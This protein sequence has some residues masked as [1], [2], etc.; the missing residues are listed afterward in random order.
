MCV[1]SSRSLGLRHSR[2][3][4]KC[5]PPL[6]TMLFLHR[7]S[8]TPFEYFALNDTRPPEGQGRG[9]K[10]LQYLLYVFFSIVCVVNLIEEFELGQQSCTIVDPTGQHV[11][12]NRE[13]GLFLCRCWKSKS[14]SFRDRSEIARQIRIR[15]IVPRLPDSIVGASD[16]RFNYSNWVWARPYPRV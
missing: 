15:N 8:P 14:P 7:Q 3:L 4:S 12:I 5:L 13:G 1:R 6:P 10:T 16:L 9:I 2:Q 11:D